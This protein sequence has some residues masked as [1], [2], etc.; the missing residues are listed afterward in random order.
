MPKPTDVKALPNHRI[1]LRYD[2][3]IEGEIDLSDL[4][5]RGVCE[6]WND[7]AFFNAVHLGSHGAIEWSSDLDLCPDAMYLRLTGKSVEEVFP[8]IRVVSADA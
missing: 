5:G 1:W 8:D 7:A 4:A 2:D 6:P 3:G